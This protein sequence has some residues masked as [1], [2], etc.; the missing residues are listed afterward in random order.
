MGVFLDVTLSRVPA[1]I[2]FAEP[3]RLLFAWVEDQGYVHCGRGGELFGTLDGDRHL[4]TSIGLRGYRADETSS[5]V[6]DWFGEVRDEPRPWLWPF[7]RT[8]SDGSTAAL[9][10]GI[11]GATRIVHLGSGSG[12][13]MTCVLAEDPVDFLRLLAIGY[14]EICWNVDYAAAP[15]PLYARHEVVN[16]PYRDWVRSTFGVTIPRTALEIVRD[17]AEMGDED[18]T[19]PF[20]RLVNRLTG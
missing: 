5:Y 1:G 3:L 10:L 20:C 17:P 6:H 2:D 18:T 15:E 13:M 9:W 8:G 11:D 12:S 4:G 16:A 7:A 19:D 14:R